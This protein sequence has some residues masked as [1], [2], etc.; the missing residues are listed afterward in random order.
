MGVDWRLRLNL[1]ACEILLAYRDENTMAAKESRGRTLNTTTNT[2]IQYS[3]SFLHRKSDRQ[4]F[5]EDPKVLST[6]AQESSF[7]RRTSLN[8]GP[9]ILQVR[10]IFH[11]SV[12][13]S[14]P[15]SWANRRIHKQGQSSHAHYILSE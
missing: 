12:T 11:L 7:K 4:R 10:V 3:R 1:T 8:T 9:I 5:H 14:G 6:Q 15:S 13:I 2:H